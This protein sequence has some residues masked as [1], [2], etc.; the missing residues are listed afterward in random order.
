MRAVAIGVLIIGCLATGCVAQPPAQASANDNANANANPNETP[1]Y[2]EIGKVKLPQRPPRMSRPLDETWRLADLLVE[3]AADRHAIDDASEEDVREWAIEGFMPSQRVKRDLFH[4][5]SPSLQA[6][7]KM[8]GDGG[9]VEY[10][11]AA[12]LTARM[13][14][15]LAWDWTRLTVVQ[16]KTD[17]MLCR[18]ASV[19]IGNA[20]RAWCDRAIERYEACTE[21]AGDAVAL[22]PWN[23]L[24]RER[25]AAIRGVIRQRH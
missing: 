4:R 2:V 19:T 7:A 25:V 1:A 22:G 16:C 10:V 17:P 13:E 15:S 11:I 20:M 5:T 14:E 9:L 24:C 18:W 23:E 3:T 12:A 21:L 6:I 8:G